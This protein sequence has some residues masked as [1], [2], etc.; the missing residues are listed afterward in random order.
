MGRLIHADRD[1]AGW[2]TI[3]RRRD[4]DL[5]FLEKVRA[6]TTID[7]VTAL[8]REQSKP[9]PEWRY[10][11]LMRALKRVCLNDRL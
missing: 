4:R 2:R 6:C 9:I 1:G 11:A 5:R 8:R 7:E 10:V 3:Q